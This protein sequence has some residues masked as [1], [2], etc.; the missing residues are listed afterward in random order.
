MANSVKHVRIF[1]KV[2]ET[3][4]ELLGERY[5]S[6]VK[7]CVACQNSRTARYYLSHKEKHQKDL[8]IYY[9]AVTKKKRIEN[10]EHF[11]E[12]SRRF[13]AKH[14]ERVKEWCRKWRAENR[15]L[16]FENG[17][18]AWIKRYAMIGDQL[19][20]KTFAKEIKAF[21]R[22]CPKGYHVDHIIPLRGKT[23]NGLHVPW[24]LQYLPAE[25]NA[26]KGNRFEV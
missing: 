9:Q 18:Q 15:S 26:K 12:I 25:E 7:P 8:A 23:V 4:P 2:C 20:A 10:K 21:Y 14:P 22:G 13:H 17:K 6:G 5:G 11:R 24:N 16:W 3:H 1:G 19:I